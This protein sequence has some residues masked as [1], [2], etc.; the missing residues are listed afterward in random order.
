MKTILYI[1]QIGALL[2]CSFNK[3]IVEIQAWEVIEEQVEF[4]NDK[5]P[6]SIFLLSKE[7]LTILSDDVEKLRRALRRSDNESLSPVF[8]NFLLVHDDC[9]T[10]IP[11]SHPVIIEETEVSNNSNHTGEF[12]TTCVAYDQ[13]SNIG[14]CYLSYSCGSEC[15][16]MGLVYFVVKDDEIEIQEVFYTG[17]S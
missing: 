12:S 3:G 13:I 7:P 10:P 15:G 11:D 16:Y 4:T 17:I 6:E 14:F 8:E 2:S 5:N 9:D 1:L